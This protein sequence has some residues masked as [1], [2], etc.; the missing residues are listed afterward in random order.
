MGV[1]G[2]RH[3]LAALLGSCTAGRVRLR[4]GVDQ[5]RN[6]RL[7]RDSIRGMS[8][9]VSSGCTDDT[10]TKNSRVLFYDVLRSRIFGCKSNRR[11]MSTI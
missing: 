2:K 1:V 9:P 3:C 6:S 11:K 5:Y 8:S 10:K 7:H 4:A